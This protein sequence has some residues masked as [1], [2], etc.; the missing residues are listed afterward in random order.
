[1][2]D[3]LP[4][5]FGERLIP[6]ASVDPTLDYMTPPLNGSRIYDGMYSGDTFAADIAGGAG[7]E[8]R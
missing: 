7:A 1:M 3:L 6:E 2:E 5:G 8:A 4:K